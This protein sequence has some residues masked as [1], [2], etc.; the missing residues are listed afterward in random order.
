MGFFFLR[1]ITIEFFSLQLYKEIAL[2][3]AGEFSNR[4]ENI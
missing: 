2:I 1:E 3:H 4:K